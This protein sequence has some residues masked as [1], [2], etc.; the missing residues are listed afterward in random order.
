MRAG[1]SVVT[2]GFAGGGGNSETMKEALASGAHDIYFNVSAFAAVK[3]GCSV[4]TW[5]NA[6]S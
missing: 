3:A 6:D 2:C 5:G 1:G 4:V